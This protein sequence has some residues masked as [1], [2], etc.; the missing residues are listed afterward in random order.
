MSQAAARAASPTR[1]ETGTAA[2]VPPG[3]LS[4]GDLLRAAIGVVT[5]LAAVGSGWIVLRGGSYL[6]GASVF[7]LMVVVLSVLFAGAV[8]LVRAFGTLANG[9]PGFV[10]GAPS[11]RLPAMPPGAPQGATWTAL[12]SPISARVAAMSGRGER[13][14]V[15][16]AMLLADSPGTESRIGQER[17]VLSANLS[18]RLQTILDLGEA[19]VKGSELRETLIEECALVLGS[20]KVLAIHFTG[21]R[22]ERGAAAAPDAV[23]LV[24][25]PSPDPVAG[26]ED[27]AA[28]AGSADRE[29][30]GAAG[31]P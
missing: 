5:M 27:A 8:L 11:I 24:A 22:L 7:V 15:I 25:T 3:T 6:T 13:R 14:L 21:T 26:A 10:V 1:R 31:S 23:D 4:D 20:G 12:V 28:D 30:P 9:L 29:G 19:S 17:A 18:Q 2:M 16:D